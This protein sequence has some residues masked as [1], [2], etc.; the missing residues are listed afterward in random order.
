M[1]LLISAASTTAKDYNNALQEPLKL[2]KL[3]GGWLEKS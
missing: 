3:Q 1:E 2:S